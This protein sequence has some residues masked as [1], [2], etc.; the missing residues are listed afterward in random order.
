MAT[1]KRQPG[2]QREKWKGEGQQAQRR[3]APGVFDL[4]EFRDGERG[5]DEETEDM[6][7]Q[8]RRKCR[9]EGDKPQSRNWQPTYAVYRT[10]ALPAE[11]SSGT[12]AEHEPIR[13]GLGDE[14]T[15]AAAKQRRGGQQA[16]GAPGAVADKSENADKGKRESTDFGKAARESPAAEEEKTESRE[17]VR[18]RWIQVDVPHVGEHGAGRGCLRDVEGEELVMPKW[19]AK[20]IAELS[21]GVEGKKQ[22]EERSRMPVN[23]VTTDREA[24]LHRFWARARAAARQR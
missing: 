22:K 7:E 20:G 24:L 21:G 5:P 3:D 18:E 9:R 10:A 2:K 8:K 6:G 15:G 1:E 13:T 11:Q 12:Q 23:P 4:K 19:G 16:P 14:F 17:E